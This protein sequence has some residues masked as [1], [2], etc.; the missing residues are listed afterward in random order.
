VAL[1]IAVVAVTAL[2]VSADPTT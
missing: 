1:F 2:L